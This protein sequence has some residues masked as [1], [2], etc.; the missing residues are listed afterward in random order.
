LLLLGTPAGRPRP[1]LAPLAAAF[2]VPVA[3]AVASG[4]FDDLGGKDPGTWWMPRP[5]GAL[6][7]T[8]LHSWLMPASQSWL[9]TAE[10]SPID[11]GLA[12][13]TAA[14]AVF[15][16][17]LGRR[18]DVGRLLVAA[19]LYVGALLAI[20][21]LVL[22]VFWN[23]TTVPAVV[24]LVV[25][26]AA[27]AGAARTA[28][29]RLALALA[30]AAAAFGFATRWLGAEARRPL[31][32]WADVAAR[33]LLHEQPDDLV[34]VHPGYAT[35]ALRRHLDGHGPER[36]VRI[37]PR[38]IEPARRARLA[39]ERSARRGWST[40]WIVLRLDTPSEADAATRKALFE[41]V[42]LGRGGHPVRAL[43]VSALESAMRPGLPELRGQVE[44]ELTA[45]LGRPTLRVDEGQFVEYQFVSGR[46]AAASES[47]GP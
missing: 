33:M 45:A 37:P 42:A 11:L 39:V 41:S 9:P 35:S 43:V 40:I 34:L 19:A 38:G 5:D 1:R 2:A 21:W 6:V 28:R 30:L 27:G 18:R 24:L 4:I 20:S 47:P 36:L 22:P 16:G 26:T 32:P 12:A 10:R 7:L 3:V 31:E 15:A 23:R 25:A 17:L 46:T 13:A 14:L 29:I 44:A 8:S